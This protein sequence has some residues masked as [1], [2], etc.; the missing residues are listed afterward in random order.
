MKID[1][2]LRRTC[3]TAGMFGTASS[4]RCKNQII[5]ERN[6]QDFET[7]RILFKMEMNQ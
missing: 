4:D 1:H 7:Q 2:E 6:Y 3:E 5:D